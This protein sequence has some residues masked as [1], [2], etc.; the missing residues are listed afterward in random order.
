M[1]PA[2]DSLEWRLAEAF[3]RGRA[4]VQEF[5]WSWKNAPLQHEEFRRTI[6][7]SNEAFRSS[8]Q[9]LGFI[10]AN[11]VLSTIDAY[12]TVRLRRRQNGVERE[13]TLRVDI[14]FP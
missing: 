6:R 12:A 8:L 1:P 11:H 5:R 13:T 14:P 7:Q 2:R 10:I 4:V 9:D 3:Y